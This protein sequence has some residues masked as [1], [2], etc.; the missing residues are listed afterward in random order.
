MLPAYLTHNLAL[1]APLLFLGSSC[2]TVPVAPSEAL[3][4]DVVPSELRGRASAIRSV[5]R[6]L[7]A[8][9]PF[10]V[11]VL[12]DATSLNTALALVTPLYAIGG[13][14]MLL[15]AKTYPADLAFVAADAKARANV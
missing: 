15:A 11:G 6:A 4:S 9:A 7:S 3:V 13:L 2:M 8:L 14:V 12:S 10:V 1:A 5:V